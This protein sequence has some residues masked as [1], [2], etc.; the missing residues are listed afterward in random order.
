MISANNELKL[1]ISAAGYETVSKDI[2]FNKGSNKN[3]N[4]DLGNI[5][6]ATDIKVLK[7]VVIQSRKPA[8]E[9]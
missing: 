3:I 9:Y 8:M 2:T 1:V 6:L 4:L 5:T 7:G